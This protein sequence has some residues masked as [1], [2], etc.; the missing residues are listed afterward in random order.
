M[1]P[2]LPREN[3]NKK[4][5]GI[6]NLKREMEQFVQQTKDKEKLQADKRDGSRMVTDAVN[7]VEQSWQ[8]ALVVGSCGRGWR[9]RE[10]A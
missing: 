7:R 9:E 2:W 6:T 1:N 5:G 4:T 8:Q 10:T 3:E